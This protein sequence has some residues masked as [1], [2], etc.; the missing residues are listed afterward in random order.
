MDACGILMT[1]TAISLAVGIT[2]IQPTVLLADAVGSHPAIVLRQ[3]H[4]GF[5]A[6]MQLVQEQ[7][8]VHGTP[9]GILA[10]KNNVGN[11]LIMLLLLDVKLL[12]LIV[13]GMG[14]IAARRLV[15]FLLIIP[16][17]LVVWMG[18]MS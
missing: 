2:L 18:M 17:M 16:Q 15:G 14:A 8:D 12:A 7:V 9:H 3:G 13:D 10:I 4:A 11:I 6:P 5:T 1:I